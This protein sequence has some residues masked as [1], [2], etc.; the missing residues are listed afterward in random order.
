MAV[1]D[2]IIFVNDSVYSV[3]NKITFVNDSVWIQRQQHQEPEIC[4]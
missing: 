4:I 3:Y 1:Y 2:Q